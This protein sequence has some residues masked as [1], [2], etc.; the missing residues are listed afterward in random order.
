MSAAR[1]YR[2]YNVLNAGV[3]VHMCIVSVRCPYLTGH[4]EAALK[5]SSSGDSRILVGAA[6]QANENDRLPTV[7]LCLEHATADTVR[8]LVFYLYTDEI[9]SDGV[10]GEMLGTLGG[11]AK[12][13]LLPR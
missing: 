12:E 13:L 7:A 1:P 11:L 5:H 6:Q 4:I 2:Q 3:P 9:P 10:S 8:L